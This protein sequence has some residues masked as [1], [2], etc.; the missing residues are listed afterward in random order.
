V[1]STTHRTSK[2]TV[3]M[4]DQP[5]AENPKIAADSPEILIF[6]KHTVVQLSC[7][8]GNG[9]KHSTAADQP[10]TFVGHMLGS[11]AETP[12]CSQP[13]YSLLLNIVLLVLPVT[14]FI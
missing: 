8:S 13:L 14:C 12:R 1:F 6:I 2:P 11:S 10:G 3:T 5:C 7:L 4:A 9:V